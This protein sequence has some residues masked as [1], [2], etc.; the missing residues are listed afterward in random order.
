M[1]LDDPIGEAY[2][3]YI[4]TRATLREV[5]SAHL[6][7]PEVMAALRRSDDGFAVLLRALRVEVKDAVATSQRGAIT[8]TSVFEHEALELH[9]RVD[10]L[11]ARIADIEAALTRRDLL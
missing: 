7:P 5:V 2:R 3:E 9:R 10:A 11:G 6:V 8:S 1:I 4:A